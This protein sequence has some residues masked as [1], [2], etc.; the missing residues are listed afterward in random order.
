M[1]RCSPVGGRRAERVG[2]GL[3]VLWPAARDVVELHR[4]D[5][6]DPGSRSAASAG[7][8]ARVCRTGGSRSITCAR[9]P[10]AGL[11]SVGV[12]DAPG[13]AGGSAPRSPTTLCP[14]SGPRPGFDGSSRPCVTS[15]SRMPGAARSTSPPTTCRS[16]RAVP[17][18][19]IHYGARLLGER[20]GALGPGRPDPGRTRARAG[21][22][23]RPVTAARRRPATGV[24]AGA[25]PVYRSA[26]RSRGDRPNRARRG[27][28]RTRLEGA[29][30]AQPDAAPP[31]LPPRVRNRTRAACRP[32]V[33]EPARWWVPGATRKTRIEYYWCPPR[34]SLRAAYSVVQESP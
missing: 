8:A 15:G 34:R 21:R 24:P 30:R 14:A 12:A 22:R 25:V 6:T 17:G 2:R 32:Q 23:S 26:R 1:A 5:R 33:A 28:W 9:R 20:R 19:P 13:S 11:R 29:S 18:R 10:T 4:P 16:S 31:R 27:A 3:A 7:P